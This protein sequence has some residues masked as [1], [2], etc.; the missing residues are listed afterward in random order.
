MLQKLSLIDLV[1]GVKNK[2]E[3]KTDTPCY[4]EW[5]ANESAP[6]YYIEAVNKLSANTKTM[7]SE[8]CT[9]LIHIISEEE[10][11]N[12]Q[13]YSLIQRA[14]E[15]LTEDINLPEGFELISQVS[16][17]IISDKK[18]EDGEEHVVI[19]YDFKV[20]YGFKMKI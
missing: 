17:G 11:K 3:E 10:Q 12:V 7:F 9:I 20:S 4:D 13:A 5:P 2:L 15:A 6:L 14:E 18:D 19:V 1:K 8:V 16:Q